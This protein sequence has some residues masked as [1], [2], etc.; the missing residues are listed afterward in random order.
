MRAISVAAFGVLAW[1][2]FAQP[3]LADENPK[4]RAAGPARAELRPRL[5]LQPATG[6]DY[7]RGPMAATARWRRTLP[8]PALSFAL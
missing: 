6:P 4:P 5:K 7:K 1:A 8:N 3:A 2:G